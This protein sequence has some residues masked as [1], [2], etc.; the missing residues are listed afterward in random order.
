[1]PQLNSFQWHAEIY[2]ARL[3]HTEVQ[4]TPN[5]A[6]FQLDHAKSNGSFIQ[7]ESIHL[8]TLRKFQSIENGSILTGETCVAGLI[9][10]SPWVFPCFQL[11]MV[12]KHLT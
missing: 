8:R 4:P 3:I 10:P 1:M 7:S 11:K 5:R 9:L 2:G 12:D 6:T